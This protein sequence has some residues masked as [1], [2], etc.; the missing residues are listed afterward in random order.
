MWTRAS[1]EQAFPPLRSL[2]NQLYENNVRTKIERMRVTYRSVDGAEGLN[3]F[4]TMMAGCWNVLIDVTIE[5]LRGA[6]VN[7]VG[8]KGWRAYPPPLQMALVTLD[9]SHR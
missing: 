4:F 3:Q 9:S 1:T 7:L 6:R 8:M 5:R 2:V